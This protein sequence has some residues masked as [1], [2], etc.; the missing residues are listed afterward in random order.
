MNDIENMEN[1]STIDYEKIISYDEAINYIE[2][3]P[4]FTKKHSLEHTS[5]FLEELMID[6]SAMK[7]IHVAGT[8]GKG[9]VCAMLSNIF[10][11]AGKST[12]LFTSPHLIAHNERIRIDNA[13]VDD[14]EFL[15]SFERVKYT[16]DKM[17]NQG[18]SHP[19]Y[20]EFLFLM[21][22]VIF[23]KRK[24]EYVILETGLG[25]RLDA[26]NSVKK[27][28]LT[29]IT[30]VGL[31]HMEYLG[32]TVGAIAGEKAGIIKRRV[33]VVYWAED[34]E[35]E[36][37]IA[38][39]ADDMEALQFPVYEKD[40][41]IIRKTDKSI[42]FSVQNGYYLNCM[43]TIPFMSEYQVKNAMVVLKAL[44]VMCDCAFHSGIVN[45]EKND[46]LNKN[47]EHID[48]NVIKKAISEVRWEGRMEIVRPGVIFDGAHNGPGID[49]FVKTFNDY[50]CEGSK[51]ILF[52]VVKD[53][54][55]EY[56]VRAISKTDV[57]KI[58]IT[59]LTS[60][61]A[62]SVDK[63]EKDFRNNDCKAELKLVEDIGE[64][65]SLAIAEKTDKDVLF[66]A[67]SLYLIGELK[68]IA[69]DMK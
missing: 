2:E 14:V 10:V 22:M 45:H 41:K 44:A 69:A 34:S 65:Y 15:E 5:R 54:D 56:M 60:D 28:I 63:I 18:Y 8:N 11:E 17:E 61:R 43:F 16:V 32:D 50:N 23:S 36:N 59:K 4:K 37:V 31:D 33:P 58:Y 1:Q 27:P 47:S 3:I 12:G 38:K 6:E 19:S 9:S 66:C 48:M 57:S 55:Y 51:N 64:A 21:A 53:K 46:E 30:Q 35:V 13:P 52:A 68:K 20:F 62:L 25:G 26:T 7:I 29:M 49:E 39:K 24:V 42:D 67:G 40:Y